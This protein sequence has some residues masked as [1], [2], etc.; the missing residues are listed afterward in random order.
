MNVKC[1]CFI[2]GARKHLAPESAIAHIYPS[3]TDA[4]VNHITLI[5]GENFRAKQVEWVTLS[6]SG[7]SDEAINIG[8]LNVHIC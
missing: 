8:M 2:S 1:V 4:E 5:N 7:L 3:I 6:T